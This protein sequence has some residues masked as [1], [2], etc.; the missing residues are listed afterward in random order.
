MTKLNGREVTSI[1]LANVN[2]KDAPDF[3]DA[4]ISSAK[5]VDTGADLEES[6]LDELSNSDDLVAEL[7]IQELIGHAERIVDMIYDR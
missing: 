5:W 6:E 4:Y 7:A 1:E 2:S 3:C